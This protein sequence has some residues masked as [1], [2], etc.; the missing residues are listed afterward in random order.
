MK[1]ASLV[2]WYKGRQKCWIIKRGTRNSVL[3][4]F[5]DGTKMITVN[6]LCWRNKKVFTKFSQFFHRGYMAK[7]KERSKERKSSVPGV[8][9]EYL[10]LDLEGGI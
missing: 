4:K 10:E 6:R 2:R 9:V 7:K 5:E 8:V 1:V 3:V